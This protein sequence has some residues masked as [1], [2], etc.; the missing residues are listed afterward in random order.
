MGSMGMIFSTNL[1]VK[2][3]QINVF[4]RR[5]TSTQQCIFSHFWPHLLFL[6]Q[7]SERQLAQL[8]YGKHTLDRTRVSATHCEFK[9]ANRPLATDA[10][11]RHVS[12]KRY[13]SAWC[14][15]SWCCYRNRKLA[16][17]Q[18]GH[19]FCYRLHIFDRKYWS[20]RCCLVGTWLF[21]TLILKDQTIIP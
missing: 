8:P 4:L 5:L 7:G 17:R 11:F 21:R 1:H 2:M 14:I 15:T 20:K 13:G 12:T 9:P 10:P 16:K 18:T 6:Q 19:L 3:L